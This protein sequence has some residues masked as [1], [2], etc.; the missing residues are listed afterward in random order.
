M[1]GTVRIPTQRIKRVGFVNVAAW[2]WYFSTRVGR[3]FSPIMYS[4]QSSCCTA[5]WCWR[6]YFVRFVIVTV[7]SVWQWNMNRWTVFDLDVPRQLVCNFRIWKKCTIAAYVNC[8]KDFWMQ[9]LVLG[10]WMHVVRY[11]WDVKYITSDAFVCSFRTVS[12]VLQYFTPLTYSKVS[13]S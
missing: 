10:K 9:W 4:V 2:W 3:L 8:T 1:T 7:T 12:W 6:F 13:S 5:S 11:C